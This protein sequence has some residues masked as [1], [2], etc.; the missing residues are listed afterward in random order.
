M[1]RLLGP[2]TCSSLFHQ[3]DIAGASMARLA[4]R[5]SGGVLLAACV[6]A[7]VAA[8]QEHPQKGVS[9]GAI[10]RH[11]QLRSSNEDV[12]SIQQRL[13]QRNQTSP[14]MP[15]ER[16]TRLFRGLDRDGDLRLSRSEVAGLPGLRARFDQYDLNH[17]HRLDYTEFGHYADTA[18]DDLQ[19]TP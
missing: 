16:L 15:E 4:K 3:P 7:S 8:A 1:N 2:V 6:A 10:E 17:D 12:V 19:H 9:V 18:Q 14:M 13:A 5:L 11:S